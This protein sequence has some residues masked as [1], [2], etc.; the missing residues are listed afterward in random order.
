MRTVAV[1]LGERRYEVLIGP[2]ASEALPSVVPPAARRAVVVTQAGI[3]VEVDPG[4]EHTV[5][6]IPR[7]ERSKSLATVEEVTRAFARFGLTRSDVVIGVG[8]GLV[9]DVAGFA[10]AIWHR[11]TPVVH[12]ATTL[13]GQVDAAIGGKTAV[14]LPEGKNLVG[15]FWQPHAVICDTATLRTLPPGEWRSGRGEVVKYEF[16]GAPGVT[17]LPL[18]EQVHACVALKAAV[19]VA[20]ERESGSR[21]TLNYG[22]TLAHALE[23]AGFAGES[24]DLED[25][26]ELADSGHFE[27]SGEPGGPRGTAALLRHGEAV[28]V[29]L[30][31]A[32]RLARALGRIG[33]ERVREHDRL[34]AAADLPT[35][36]P[37]GADPKVLIGLMG[38]DKKAHGDL[39]FVLD[40]PDGVE[41]VRGVDPAVV[42]AVLVEMEQEAGN[43]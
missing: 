1:E 19:V 23:A 15:A 34:V 38:R 13:L 40:G 18:E 12:V 25:S 16:I 32:A 41:P 43:G 10:A 42:E 4:I 24:G 26:G 17:A 11:G 36:L 37:P 21:M 14:N 9:T 33:D 28:A 5:V 7:G 29:G 39:T 20:D 31:Y 3:G 6:E 2:G 30:C 22:H 27:E 8:G 35:C